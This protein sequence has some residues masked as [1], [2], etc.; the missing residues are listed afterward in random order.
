MK[1]IDLEYE[2]SWTQERLGEKANKIMKLIFNKAPKILRL[3][4]KLWRW[5]LVS[6]TQDIYY[7]FIGRT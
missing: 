2:E 3:Q 4:Y 5:S 7:N 1:P 6:Y